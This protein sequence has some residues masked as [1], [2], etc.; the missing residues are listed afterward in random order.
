MQQIRA[1]IEDLGDEA[2]EEQL[3]MAVAN[4]GRRAAPDFQLTRLISVGIS[5]V[6]RHAAHV[7]VH[8]GGK[9]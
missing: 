7:V 8:H 5:Y 2:L 6:E 3:Q 4:E 1:R 9:L